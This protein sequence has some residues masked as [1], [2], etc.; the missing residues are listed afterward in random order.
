MRGSETEERLHAAIKGIPGKQRPKPDVLERAL[1]RLASEPDGQRVAEVIASGHFS[2]SD[3][4][5]Q[6]VSSLGARK[7]AMFQPGADQ[8]IF[9]EDL[10]RSGVPAH[11][12]DFE[13]KI[14]VGSDL[15]IRI[16]E[17]TGE[18]YGY[19]MKHLND[20]LDPVSEITRGKYLLQLAKSEAE[21]V[22]QGDALVS[23]RVQCPGYWIESGTKHRA[24]KLFVIQVDIWKSSLL[25]VTLETYSDAW[26]TMDTRE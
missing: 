12:I 18:V 13:H 15:D 11:T 25:V 4:F 6:V 5:G 9:A 17:E 21:A 14:P 19:Q 26:L 2:K 23:F 22:A 10:V 8:I 16:R 1:E 24:E 3:G 7:E 20:P